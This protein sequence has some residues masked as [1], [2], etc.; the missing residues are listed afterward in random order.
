MTGEINT[1]R[2]ITTTKHLREECFL[3]CFLLQSEGCYLPLPGK[4]PAQVFLMHIPAQGNGFL[5]CHISLLGKK[6]RYPRDKV[7]NVPEVSPTGLCTLMTP[8]LL[9][10]QTLTNPLQAG[11]SAN[12]K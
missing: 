7:Q 11:V 9:N 3:E 10:F 5:L 1:S 2:G 4:T 6:L 8:S 12:T